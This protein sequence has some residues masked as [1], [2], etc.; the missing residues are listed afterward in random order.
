M[1]QRPRCFSKP[2]GVTVFVLQPQLLHIKPNMTCV[3]GVHVKSGH[4]GNT[5]PKS[6]YAKVLRES[7]VF[8][9]E[10]KERS[11]KLASDSATSAPSSIQTEESGKPQDILHWAS[12]LSRFPNERKVVEDHSFHNASSV[13]NNFRSETTNESQHIFDEEY[14]GNITSALTGLE[15][16]SSNASLGD[17]AEEELLNQ[18]DHQYFEGITRHLTYQTDTQNDRN[19]DTE[20]SENSR[21]VTSEG[22][23][24]NNLFTESVKELQEES[25]IF[26]RHYFGD[27]DV[28]S[29]GRSL[30]DV[31]E[32]EPSDR[33]GA[34]H[35]INEEAEKML[36][37]PMNSAMVQENKER[38]HTKLDAE[39]KKCMV[40]SINTSQSESDF[41]RKEF[42][43]QEIK[44][45]IA[46]S[47]YNTFKEIKQEF[48]PAE[49]VSDF[50]AINITPNE[51]VDSYLQ[52][53]SNIHISLEDKMRLQAQRESLERGTKLRV[54][55]GGIE[56][57]EPEVR[58]V[59]KASKKKKVNNKPK[60]KREIKYTGTEDP[61]IPVSEHN[62]SGCGA[63]LHCQEQMKPG[64]MPSEKFKPL[65]E[66]S[67]LSG[68]VCQRCWYFVNMKQ[69]LNVN[70]DA[71]DYSKI[72][73]AIQTKRADILLMVDLV[74]VPCSV[75]PDLKDM[76]GPRRQMIIVGNKI[77]LLPK[78]APDY[79]KRV[80]KNL[81][82]MCIQENVCNREQVQ[83]VHLISAKTGYGIEN[84]ITMIQQ[85]WGAKK[86]IYLLGTANI[87]KSTLFNTL[88]NSDLS[89]TKA[90]YLIKKATISRWPGTTLSLLKFPVM[91]PTKEKL[92][93]RNLRLDEERKADSGKPRHVAIDKSE[94]NLRA[95]VKGNVG[96]SFTLKTI[97]DNKVDDGDI[98]EEQLPVSGEFEDPFHTMHPN[99]ALNPQ[100][101][102]PGER[103]SE[104]KELPF[105]FNPQEFELG[106]WFYDTPGV[107]H[108][109]QMLTHLTMEE[110]KETMPNKVII[111]RTL[112]IK[113]GQ[114]I[115]LG[116]LGRLDYV[117][118]VD[119][120]YFTV[121][122]SEG[123][124]VPIGGAER[125]KT[126]PKLLPVDFEVEG[127]GWQKSASDI[128]L[129]SAGWVSI[130][131]GQGMLAQLRAF[132]P[133]G[134]G[135]FKRQPALLPYAI[136]MKGRRLSKN[137]PFYHVDPE[138][139]LKYM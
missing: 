23:N 64:Y 66:A 49:K 132:T 48:S 110:L 76:V 86:D 12:K 58:E 133:N 4:S 127:C 102:S 95:Y 43:R 59:I 126:F 139:V 94:V 69:A 37:V 117:Q 44:S 67:E 7:R 22:T 46:S 116:G 8:R 74:D 79:L 137:K 99:I 100:L 11:G 20:K 21:N 89:K 77:D 136:N 122:A 38:L 62:C 123:I 9:G 72:I 75:I 128:L 87:G 88:L 54:G 96:K 26:D 57:L 97:E 85:K 138:C 121:F 10:R 130:T 18:F 2:S 91:K 41:F 3:A 50:A 19:S 53:D 83:K 35:L 129:S 120:I 61:T 107:L 45:S 78:D 56:D 125:M 47:Q 29:Q 84:L 114:V 6:R 34:H 14:F 60:L 42:L 16:S 5:Q 92:F 33:N 119:S 36:S 71:E 13:I 101:P 52:S 30:I 27:D 113:P 115:F 112:I 55:G 93:K 82:E 135:C 40:Q 111:P 65:S 98:D 68:A 24:R 124:P 134:H 28:S 39:D 80:E 70:V 51:D 108:D 106:K 17:A 81:L 131:A 118:G 31:I 105:T 90:H 63:P 104:K 25:N 1:I 109:R 73:R 103:K 32:Q 15:T